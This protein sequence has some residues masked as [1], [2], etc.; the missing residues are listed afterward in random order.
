MTF[1]DREEAGRRLAERLEAFREDRPVVLGLA[2]GGVPVAAEVARALG[3]EIDVLVVRKLAAP[4]FPEYAVGAIA[5]GGAIVLNREAMRDVGLGEEEVAGLAEGEALEL[6]R[7]VRALRGGRLLRDVAGRTVIL[8]DDGVATGA[9]ARAAARAAR[10]RGAA[11]VV[12]ATPVI[13]AASEPEL[14]SDFDAIVAVQRPEVFFAVGQW[15]ERF[16]Q[17]SDA[18]VVAC[19]RR[20]AS[21]DGAGERDE[22]VGPAPV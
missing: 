14:R 12:L 11:R 9:T 6:A 3:A 8:V 15:Y 21:P 19:L 7:R 5:E 1:Q 16:E 20:A 4:R 22:A 13:A 18:D 2:R 17:V 10:E